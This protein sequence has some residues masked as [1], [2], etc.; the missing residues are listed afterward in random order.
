MNRTRKI[1]ALLAS[2]GILL[3]QVGFSASASEKSSTITVCIEKFSLG[4]GFV[5]E[6]T[7]VT[8]ADG[9][10]VATVMERTLGKEKINNRNGCGTFISSF[11]DAKTTIN[12]PAFISDATTVNDRREN[13]AWLSGGDYTDMSCWLYAVNGEIL[14]VGIAE[15]QPND[16]DVVSFKYSLVGYGSDIGYDT[17]Y[18]A[19]WGGMKQ[20]VTTANTTN[21]LK[22][23]GKANALSNKSSDVVTAYN[24]ASTVVS[25]LESTQKSVDDAY[26]K[27]Y[28]AMNPAPDTPPVTQPEKKNPDTGV[29][30]GIVLLGV[31]A[32]ACG[33]LLS[34]K[35]R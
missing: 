12:V 31:T 2:C 25:N 22:L 15:Y 1:T 10:T 20:L 17:S 14:S 27:L 11:A 19:D 13:A 18:M 26:K 9:D 33:I 30:S 24:N 16:G 5:T 3:S 34:R 35:K 7:E 28:D 21:L 8:L 29:V 32:S 4:Q 6:P 23:M